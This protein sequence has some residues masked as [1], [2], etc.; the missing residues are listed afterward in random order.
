MTGIGASYAAGVVVAS[1]FVR[2]GR[3]TFPVRSVDL[4]D[5][6]DMADCILAFSHRGTS[7]EVAQSLAAHPNLPRLAVTKDAASPI[8]RGADAHVLLQNGEDATPSSTAY[9]GALAVAGLICERLCGPT[10]TVWD[11]IPGLAREILD[12]AAEKMPR[13]RKTFENRRA[14]DCVGAYASFG[15][16]DEA[17]LLLREAARI[18]ASGYDTRHY[19]HGP[20]ESMDRNTGVVIFG[21]G[22]E[23]EI[24]RQ[25]DSVG[26]PVFLLTANDDIG[27]GD[28]LTVMRIP[29]QE[30]RI[31]RGIL[32][33]LPAQLLAAELSDAASL[34]DTKFRYPQADTKIVSS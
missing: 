3:R 16:A 34:T 13:L 28:Y 22:R 6:G 10:A 30:S 24:A 21:D 8:A 32:D 4:I 1:E 9:T 26:C 18:P 5:G 11:A 31:A 29:A 25:F 14:I 12:R 15:T 33:I 7:A 23:L 20:M 2:R 19:L 17:S 27:D